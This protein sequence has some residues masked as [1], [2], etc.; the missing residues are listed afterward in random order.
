MITFVTFKWKPREGY[1][2][3]FDSSHV[4]T[5]ASMIDRHYH[6][7]HRFV[8]VTDDTDG[9]E[10]GI[11]TIP[12]WSDH[13]GFRN[14]TWPDGPNCFPRLKALSR[15]FGEEIGTRYVCLDLDLVIVA[16]IT[17]MFD[18]PQ[19]FAMMKSHIPA[20]P[21]CGSIVMSDPGARSEVWE[22]FNANPAKAIGEMQRAGRRG[23][24][25]AWI[26]HCLGGD[27]AGWG[28]AEGV[29]SYMQLVPKASTSRRRGYVAP[30]FPNTNIGKL[31]PDAKIIVFTGK[32]DPWDPEARKLS[33]WI[34]EHY[35]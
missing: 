10:W 28:G 27:I 12:L 11:E 31:P 15:S 30:N 22:R 26:T 17:H 33:P 3:K 35:R 13:A 5:L 21:L 16:D 2:S 14:P 4:N 18:I 9:L 8:C 34:N 19:S 20:I 6:K 24:D 32:P 1:R 25:Q 7:P 29:Y 23:S